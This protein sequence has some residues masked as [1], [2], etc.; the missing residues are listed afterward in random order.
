MTSDLGYDKRMTVCIVN[1]QNTLH[2]YELHKDLEGEKGRRKGH[3][4]DS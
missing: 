1:I 3:T 2:I 4:N